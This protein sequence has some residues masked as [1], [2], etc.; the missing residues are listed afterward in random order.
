M[1]AG[2]VIYFFWFNRMV[3]E[4][5]NRYAEDKA[6]QLNLQLVSVA[7]LKRR[8]AILSNGKPG[9]KSEFLFEFSS[10]G[11]HLYQGRLIMENDR[12]KDLWMPPH[13]L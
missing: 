1:A 13:R 3:A 9:M 12:L 10:D 2:A 11:E 6:K 8:P 4:S 5:A 7:C